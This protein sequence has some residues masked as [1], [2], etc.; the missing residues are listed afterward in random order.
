MDSNPYYSAGGFVN[1]AGGSPYGA[2]SQ[3]PGGKASRLD[4]SLMLNAHVEC[5]CAHYKRRERADSKL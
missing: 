5:S 2:S 1:A 3:S 4:V